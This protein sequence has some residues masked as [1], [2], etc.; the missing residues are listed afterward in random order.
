MG[1]A[2]KVQPEL[3]TRMQ[4]QNLRW[5]Y[6]DLIALKPIYASQGT[7]SEACCRAVLKHVLKSVVLN[8]ILADYIELCSS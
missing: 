6:Q 8:C 1:G 5:L 7:G 4:K 2:G 3:V